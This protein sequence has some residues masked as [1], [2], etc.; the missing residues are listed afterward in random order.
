MLTLFNK[1][2]GTI[3]IL[4]FGAALL[5]GRIQGG[6]DRGMLTYMKQKYGEDF[7]KA[8]MWNGQFGKNYT[9]LGK[10]QIKTGGNCAGQG[11][12]YRKRKNLSGQLPGSALQ[13]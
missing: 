4:L 10:K 11:A 8:E 3:L 1:K 12:L 5:W 7:E 6:S 9:M 13:G 2:L